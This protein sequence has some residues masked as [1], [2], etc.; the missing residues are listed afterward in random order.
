MK[1][2]ILQPKG[3]VFSGEVESVTLPGKKGL[4]TVL[5]GHAAIITSLQSGEIKYS[6]KG[7]DDPQTTKVDN[8]GFV[9]VMRNSVSVC[10]N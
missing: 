5:K 9:K 1:L 2:T 10:I 4:F 3:T 7:N 8:G 6:V